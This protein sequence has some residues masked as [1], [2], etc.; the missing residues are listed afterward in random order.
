[1]NQLPPK[2]DDQ[3][4]PQKNEYPRAISFTVNHSTMEL[5]VKMSTVI[6]NTVVKIIKAIRPKREVIL[7]WN[8]DKDGNERFKIDYKE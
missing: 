1:M 7:E 4:L 6:C 2:K 3:M 5:I 8:K